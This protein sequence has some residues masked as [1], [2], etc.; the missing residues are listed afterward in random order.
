[1][2]ACLEENGGSAQSLFMKT[3]KIQSWWWDRG[4]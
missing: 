4:T 1:M 2:N 3:I